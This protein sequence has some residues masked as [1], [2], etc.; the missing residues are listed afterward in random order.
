MDKEKLTD[1]EAKKQSDKAE[2]SK[3]V[4]K[5]ETP[6]VVLDSPP[7]KD[8]SSKAKASLEDVA[9]EVVNGDWGKG[10]E[11]R[12]KLSEAGFN[13][14]EVEEAVVKLMNKST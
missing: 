6:K 4:T 8:S 1:D 7:K 12:K 5:E 3:H 9:K 11:R 10:Q 14:N 2:G 13:V